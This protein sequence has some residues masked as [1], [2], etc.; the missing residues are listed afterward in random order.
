VPAQQERDWDC[1]FASTSLV[2]RETKM[3]RIRRL[4]A[5]TFLKIAQLHPLLAAVF[6]TIARFR[7]LLFAVFLVS[8]FFLF[9]YF[10]FLRTTVEVPAP[11]NALTAAAT[12]LRPTT[13]DSERLQRNRELAPAQGQ[14]S[15]FTDGIL[16]TLPWAP[17]TRAIELR[18][19]G[20]KVEFVAVRYYGFLSDTTST[21]IA[22]G[23]LLP[24]NPGDPYYRLRFASVVKLQ[25]AST[26]LL[27]YKFDFPADNGGQLALFFNHSGVESRKLLSRG[28]APDGEMRE[29]VRGEI[30]PLSPGSRP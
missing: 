23:T 26:P 20:E 22:K 13:S 14:W 24:P 9:R 28:P 7:S 27:P 5:A 30:V 17:E 6:L 19:Q 11:G 16:G 3:A 4:L 21:A 18:V 1:L 29:F 25:G 12:P 10:F 8:A 15:L 2:F